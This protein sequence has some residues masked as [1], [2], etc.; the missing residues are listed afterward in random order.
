MIQSISILLL[1]LFLLPD[2]NGSETTSW[3]K[4][5]IRQGITVSERW[6]SLP[7][8]Q[9]TR[10][11]KGEF[12]TRAKAE[13]LIL[14]LN[15]TDNAT[16]WMRAVS[17]H[18]KLGSRSQNQWYTYTIYDIPWPFKSQDLI[19]YYQCAETKSRNGYQVQINSVSGA[20]PLGIKR[21]DRPD[22]NLKRLSNYEAE[23]IIEELTPELCS[24]RFTASSSDPPP[25]PRWM[26][27]PALIRLFEDNLIRF[28]AMSQNKILK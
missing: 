13:D 28:R 10:Q 21:P 2:G 3:K 16:Q 15:D 6:I 14:L 9:K 19:S 7:D 22:K 11:R 5:H 8:G 20:I 23:W 17:R 26:M 25:F 24:V 18:E 1:S 12:T 27:D 4:V